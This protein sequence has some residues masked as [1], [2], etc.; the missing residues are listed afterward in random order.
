MLPETIGNLLAGLGLF[1]I[2]IRF[3]GEHMK[4]MT[5]RRFRRAVSR[6]TGN[7]LAAVGSGLASG[8]VMQSTTAVTFILVGLVSAGLIP[9][10]LSLPVIVWANVGTSALVL[11]AAVDSRAMALYLLGATGLCYYLNL[12]RS[13]RFRH[14]VGALLGI[15]LLFLGLQLLKTG[16]AT[17]QTVAWVARL[18][19][20]T[21]DS[22]ALAFFIGA[23]L[24]F[25]SQSSSTVSIAAIALVDTG[26]LAFQ[27]TILIV[28]GSN[29]GSAA[30]TMFMASNLRGV[31]RQPALF[32]TLFKSIGTVVL[33]SLFWAERAT[34]APLV[35]AWAGRWSADTG[36]Q[37]AA[38]YLLFQLLTAVVVSVLLGP[39]N[40]LISRASPSTPEEELARPRYLY[41]QAL[42]EPE[43]AIALVE[44]E[45][46][47]LVQRFEQYLDQVREDTAQ[48]AAISSAALHEAAA[49]V[50]THVERFTADLLDQNRSRGSVERIVRLQTRTELLLSLSE[51][52]LELVKVLERCRRPRALATLGAAMAEGA[53]LALESARDTMEAPDAANRELLHHITADRGELMEGI[54]RSLLRNA[55]SLTPDEQ[56]S[57]LSATGLFER[58]IWLLR[59]LATSLG[60]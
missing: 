46:L 12:D 45:Q 28:Y 32:Q 8:A 52:L 2:G 13:A 17:L 56:Q 40:R 58:V 14:L 54:R 25:V 10:R 38:V 20:F 18:L 16:A 41:E 31:A 22:L 37:I 30:S 23:L 39:A 47:R 53:H 29:F 36:Q 27:Q 21:R 4:Q 1:F 6:L 7:P 43:T 15:G 34:D 48:R 57:L 33:V 11:L 50:L 24:T 3:V 49:A 60:E 35:A 51:T 26:L 55:G 5:G 44:R 42:E 9:V 19:D 59:R